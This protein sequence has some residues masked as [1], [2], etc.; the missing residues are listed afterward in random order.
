VAYVSVEVD[1]GIMRNLLFLASVAGVLFAIDAFQF[2]GRYR[3]EIWQ[4]ALR[5]GQAFNREV[6]YRLRR[7]LW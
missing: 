1:R 2:G 5:K 6:E 7:S 4:D 3:T